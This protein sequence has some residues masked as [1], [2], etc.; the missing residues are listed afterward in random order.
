MFDNAK[1]RGGTVQGTEGCETLV[2]AGSRLKGEI[3]CKG[4]SR[5]AGVVDGELS[6][7]NRIVIGKDAHVHGK[8]DALE[9]EIDGR[10]TGTI[11][12][13]QRVILNETA[14]IEG[15]LHSPSVVIEEGAVFNGKSSMPS[16]DQSA[17]AP[18]IT[19][20]EPNAD[21][22]VQ[23][24]ISEDTGSADAAPE[25]VHALDIKAENTSRKATARSVREETKTAKSA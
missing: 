1:R 23:T 6:G 13:T 15:D 7:D 10:V 2:G 17:A 18:E 4:P 22:T 3:V 12:A 25:N 16:P 19:T 20:A 14:V 24:D 21:D 9:I 5:I 11:N 8:I